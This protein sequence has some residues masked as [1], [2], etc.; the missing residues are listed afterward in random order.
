[1]NIKNIFRKKQTTDEPKPLHVGGVGD[2][3]LTPEPDE[4]ELA[5]QALLEVIISE[6]KSKHRKRHKG[7]EQPKPAD[8][9]AG[10]KA[11]HDAKY[12]HNLADRIRIAYAASRQRAMRFVAWCE[13]ELQKPDIPAYGEKSLS[14][15]E[16]ELYKRIDIVDREGGD[17]KARWQHCLANVTVRLMEAQQKENK[18]K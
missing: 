1:M 13:Q 4:A 15:I 18:E 16:A 2:A 9:H 12:Y 7:K 8:R 6:R 11:P 10:A 14:L 17:L 5:A 3:P